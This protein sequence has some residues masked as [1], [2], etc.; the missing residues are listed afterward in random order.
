MVGVCEERGYV[1]AVAGKEDEIADNAGGVIESEDEAVA[2]YD[3]AY[4]RSGVAMRCAEI[5]YDISLADECV[6]AALEDSGC[7]LAASR[8]PEA[9]FDAVV[10]YCWLAEEGFARRKVF[11]VEVV[12]LVAVDFED[13]GRLEHGL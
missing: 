9:I 4:E 12:L 7:K 3:V 13:F 10:F 5:K 8:V 6:G 2:A 11:C 1:G